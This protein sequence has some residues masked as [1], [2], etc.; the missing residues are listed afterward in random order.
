MYVFNL[1]RLYK[2]PRVIIH[3]NLVFS[4]LVGQ[5]IFVFGIDTAPKV[6]FVF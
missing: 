4:M 3:A 2:K 6:K 5:L 1:H